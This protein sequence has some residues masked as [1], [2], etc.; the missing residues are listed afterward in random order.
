VAFSPDA[1]DTIQKLR[2]RIGDT[3]NRY[4]DLELWN[5]I[6]LALDEVNM[7]MESGVSYNE[8]GFTAPLSPEFKTL[9]ASVAKILMGFLPGF[10]FQDGQTQFRYGWGRL[11]EKETID[12]LVN[13]YYGEV[14]EIV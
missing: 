14:I 2:T 7:R 8:E 5:Y 12:E 4:S 11:T 13:T 10:A 6:C 9:L 1:I 3:E